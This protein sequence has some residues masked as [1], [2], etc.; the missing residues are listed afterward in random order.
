MKISPQNIPCSFFIFGFHKKNVEESTRASARKRKCFDQCACACL[1]S[2]SCVKAVFTVKQ[3]LLVLRLYLLHVFF[4]HQGRL[5]G[6]TRTLGLALV[7]TSRL[8]LASRPF[9]R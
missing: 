1:T 6:E 5:H 9:S 8:L 4:L 3:E 7:I 2:C